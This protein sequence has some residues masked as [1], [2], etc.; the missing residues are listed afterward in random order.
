MS[1]QPI[2]STD[3]VEAYVER[4]RAALADLPADDVDELTTGMA[5]DLTDARAE[6][7]G[8]WR[9]RLGEPEA[10]AAELRSAAGLPPRPSP[11]REDLAGGIDRFGDALRAQPWFPWVQRWYRLL[12]PGGWVLRGAL[13][14]ALVSEVLF[15]DTFVVPGLVVVV[16]GIVA[17]VWV[18][19][20]A[21]G[22]DVIA[23]L[24]GGVGAAV[25][26]AAMLALGSSI[27]TWGFD[28]DTY[29]APTGLN[30]DGDPVQN[31]YGYDAQG[32]RVEGLRLYD[33]YGTPMLVDT[34]EGER[35]STFPVYG[36]QTQ[37]PAVDGV[38]LWDWTPPMAVQPVP[39]AATSTESADASSTS[40]SG[41]STE[42]SSSTKGDE[43]S[44]TSAPRSTTSR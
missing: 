44:A 10:Y 25:T 3:E 7:P 14:S 18:G 29:Y 20:R 22:G 26:V 13:G 8:D 35:S 38:P 39:G 23:R 19:Q 1:T 16:L 15:G 4:V 28:E 17:S 2:Q 31:I 27:A 36:W 9:S 43:P 34:W 37:T 32:E 12:R 5:A 33:Q 21:A 6:H 40:S 30:V 41:S 24:V 42:D 11:G